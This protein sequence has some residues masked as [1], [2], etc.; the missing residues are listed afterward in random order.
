MPTAGYCNLELNPIPISS[1]LDLTLYLLVG[2]TDYYG[3]N[4]TGMPEI[5]WHIC[6]ENMHNFFFVTLLEFCCRLDL[7]VLKSCVLMTA[8]CFRHA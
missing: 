5:W 7:C 3:M 1:Q 4:Y 8:I 2:G 6:P